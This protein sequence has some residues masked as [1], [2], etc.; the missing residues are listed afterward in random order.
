MVCLN[1]DLNLHRFLIITMSLECLDIR[2]ILGCS[3][4]IRASGND[5]KHIPRLRVQRNGEIYID[6]NGAMATICLY[7]DADRF[8][9]K[10]MLYLC[11]CAG[12]TAQNLL[13]RSLSLLY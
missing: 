6:L 4:L 7:I 12:K 5:F 10:S 8:I 11:L 1:F 3:V 2:R 9:S 13:K